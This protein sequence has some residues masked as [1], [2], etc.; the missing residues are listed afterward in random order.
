MQLMSVLLKLNHQPP[1]SVTAA[2]TSMVATTP[3]SPPG[4][5]QSACLPP[6][7]PPVSIQQLAPSASLHQSATT[8]PPPVTHSHSRGTTVLVTNSSV[9]VLNTSRNS[10]PT[11]KL[12]LSSI[13]HITQSQPSNKITF[14]PPSM[15]PRTQTQNMSSQIT[16]APVDTTI[17]IHMTTPVPWYTQ[18]GVS[19]QPQSRFQ[20]HSA[21]TSH[22]LLPIRMNCPSE[23]IIF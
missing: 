15:G 16:Y 17:L 20:R 7:F 5:H 12:M 19:G 8:G 3:S 9:V 22:S 4:M 1:T 23:P 21:N 11:F 2:T 14:A 10:I 18:T 6:Y 13:P